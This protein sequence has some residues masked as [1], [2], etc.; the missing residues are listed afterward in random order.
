MREVD[1][2]TIQHQPIASI[3]LMEQAA[4][5]FVTAF[6]KKYPHQ[7][8]AILV[9]CGQGNNGGDGLAIARILADKGF[10]NI[11]VLLTHFSENSSPDYLENLD[12]LQR[13]SHSISVSRYNDHLTFSKDELVIDALLGSGLNKPL[14]EAYAAM[15]A[16]INKS[17]ATIVSVDVPTGFV[18]E[19]EIQEPYRGIK[20]DLVI[21]FQRPKINFFFPESTT[22]LKGFCI[23]PIGLDEDHL[24]SLSS[25]WKLV[26]SK[27]VRHSLKPRE[28]FSHKGSYGHVLMLAGNTE[29][30]GAALL[31]TGASLNVGAGLVT[32]CIPQSGLT[33]LNVALPEAMFLNREAVKEIPAHKYQ[34][35]AIGP[36]LGVGNE[37]IQL[38]EYL[39]QQNQ[40]LVLD[41][42]ALNIIASHQELLEKIPAQSVITPHMKEFDRLFGD[43]NNWWQRVT[44]ARQEAKQRQV[45]IVLKNQYTFICLP[46]GEICVNP[47]GNP[48]MAQGGMGDVLTGTIVGLLA[49]GYSSTDVAILG[50]YLH[51]K[52]GDALA[53]NLEVV[54]ASTLSKYLPNILR[55]YRQ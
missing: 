37:Q 29:T 23:V 55:K 43:H 45:I 38:L 26:D 54:A 19:G 10:S 35:I 22:A 1:A 8:Q 24:Q 25:D 11:R 4:V 44:T 30:M 41:A 17:G 33:A 2:H 21:S 32:A 42:D 27:F 34:A 49:Q 52:A 47:T 12:R 31:A 13:S 53:K 3:D 36:G 51:G 48:A 46:T 14:S 16:T 6:I 50:V 28:K 18:S 7:Q 20:A 5:A 39:F 15:V 40:P 9:V